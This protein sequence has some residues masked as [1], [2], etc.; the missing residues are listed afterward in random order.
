MQIDIKDI[1]SDYLISQNKHATATGLANILSEEISHDQITR[2][3]NGDLMGSK[4]LWLEIKSDVRAHEHKDKGV[5]VLD[6]MPAEKPYTDE[7]E[8]MCWHYSHAK[9]RLI[10]GVNLLTCM[11]RYGDISLPI[12]YEVVKKDLRYSDLKTR[13]ERRK[14]SITKNELFRDLISQVVSNQVKWQYLLNDSWFS[15]NE[16]MNFIHHDL[17]KF[18]IMGLKSNRSIALTVKD[19]QQ[20]RYEQIGS[21]SLENGVPKTVYLKGVSFPVQVMKKV[22]K[23]ED[24][25][26]G[27]LYLVTNDTAI[28]G[29]QIFE[30]Y[31]KR[32]CIEEYHKSVKQ[33][34]SFEKSPTKTITSQ[35]N[36]IF[37]SVLS[38]CKLERLKIKTCTNHF[39]IKYK[40]ILRSNQIALQ[41]WRKMTC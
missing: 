9:N 7:N 23:N 14:A 11:V 4:K 25:S 6:D 36:H 33:N 22:F 27:T 19:K 34:A 29:E 8:I 41:E 5:L 35:L 1:Y 16:N 39:A 31:Q 37:C 18:F 30:I 12:G 32:W 15:S 2:F 3:L 24:G 21:M 17:N 20:G 38:F 10:K 40:L 26:E 13:K 28:N